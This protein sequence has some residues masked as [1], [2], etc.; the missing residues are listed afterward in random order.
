MN[1]LSNPMRMIFC[2]FIYLSTFTK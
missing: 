2:R 1:D